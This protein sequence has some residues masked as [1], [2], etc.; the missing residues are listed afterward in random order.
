MM[1]IIAGERL[2]RLSKSIRLKVNRIFFLTLIISMASLYSVRW[3]YLYVQ[4][5]TFIQA[6]EWIEKNIPPET[7]IITTATKFNGFVPAKD[8]LE[9]QQQ[10]NKKFYESLSYLTKGEYPKNVR[11]II[12]LDQFVN[13]H[14][15]EMVKS[16]L[17]NFPVSY[18]YIINIHWDPNDT[19]LQLVFDKYQKI[20]SFSPINK[21]YSQKRIDN[22]LAT[23]N[24]P[25]L[26]ELLFLLDR[27]GPYVDIYYNQ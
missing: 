20:V 1:A 11:N 12:Y 16:T 3:N 7:L 17:H 15:Q 5:P 22:I 18:S 8:V 27:T 26:P 19:A 25:T 21:N 13:L 9:L 10:K 14:S 24:K 4:K 2:Y 6:Y 23:I